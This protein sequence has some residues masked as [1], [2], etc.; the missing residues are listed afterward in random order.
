MLLMNEQG[1]TLCDQ[2][3]VIRDMADNSGCKIVL[4]STPRILEPLNLSGELIRRMV[5]VFF[6]RYTF[7]GDVRDEDFQMFRMIVNTFMELLPKAQRPRLSSRRIQYL[8]AGSI[9][10]VGLLSMWFV[11]ALTRCVVAGSEAFEWSHFEE[12]AFS[13]A[14]LERFRDECEKGEKLYHESNVRTP[15]GLFGQKVSLDMSS[16][17]PV[18]EAPATGKVSRKRVGKPNP[19]R[20]EVKIA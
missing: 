4:V 6:Y 14:D 17:E 3:D 11:R 8:Q 7:T 13:D 18:P 2:L 19:A 10:C 15:E 1:R 12:R 9:G 20:H 5:K 16:E